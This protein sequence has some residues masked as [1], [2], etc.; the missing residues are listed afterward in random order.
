VSRKFLI[1]PP[2]FGLG[3]VHRRPRWTAGSASACPPCP[4]AP[5][6]K[7]PEHHAATVEARLLSLRQCAGRAA[8]PSP[9][10]IR[11]SRSTA[12]A[13]MRYMFRRS[14]PNDGKTTP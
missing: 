11:A 8:T 4:W 6:G 1:G 14:A 13:N 3:V 9:A 5:T 7:Y 10:K 2:D 12:V